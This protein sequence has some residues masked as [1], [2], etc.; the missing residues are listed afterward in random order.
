MQRG[1]VDSLW[2]ALLDIPR[3]LEARSYD[4][5]GDLVVETT[6]P[7]GAGEPFEPA[8]LGRWHLTVGQGTASCR[9]TDAEAALAIEVDAL[10]AAALGNVSVATLA[11]AGRVAENS[12]GGVDTLTRLL[13]T[14]RAPFNSTMF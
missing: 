9:P 11:A 8:T 1:P 7:L 3:V 10:A 2:M 6:A 14:P 5:D 4:A 13:A 12:S